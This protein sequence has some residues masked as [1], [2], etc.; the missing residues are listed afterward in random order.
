MIEIDLVICNQLGLHAR[1]ASKLVSLSLRF[2]SDINLR[3]MKNGLTANCKSIMGLMM[4]SAGCGT[5]VKVTVSGSDEVEA[6]KA[7][8]AL[9]E[10]K[11]GEEN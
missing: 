1:A 2:A 3:I 9:I 7:I 8:K 4:L 5:S 10:N 6:A 11:F